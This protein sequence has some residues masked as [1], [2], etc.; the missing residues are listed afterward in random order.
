[1]SNQNRPLDIG[2]HVCSWPS[3]PVLNSVASHPS[4]KLPSRSGPLLALLGHRKIADRRPLS[5][6]RIVRHPSVGSIFYDHLM[7]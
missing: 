7:A 5:S 4:K 3:R 2:S 6:C 1:M